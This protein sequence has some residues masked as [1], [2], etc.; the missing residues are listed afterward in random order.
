MSRAER[1]QNSGDFVSP[2]CAA[3]AEPLCGRRDRA[4]S[5]YPYRVKPLAGTATAT[6]GTRRSPRR[7]AYRNRRWRLVLKLAREHSHDL[8]T[9]LADLL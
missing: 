1:D 3:E 4:D 2:L 6:A 8:D 7:P 9:D 5:D